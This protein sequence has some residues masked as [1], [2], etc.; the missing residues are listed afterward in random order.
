MH[1]VEG[2]FSGLCQGSVPM[3]VSKV[4]FQD[5]NSVRNYV[6]TVLFEAGQFLH[7]QGLAQAALDQKAFEQA[8]K[9]KSIYEDYR[10]TVIN[11]FNIIDNGDVGFFGSKQISLFNNLNLFSPAPPPPPK[12]SETE[13]ERKKRE[14]EAFWNK[15]IGTVVA[16]VAAVLAGFSYDDYSVQ[17]K[18]LS[19][20]TNISTNSKLLQD[21]IK[22][23]FQKLISKQLKIDRLRTAKATHNF[24]PVS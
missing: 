5:Q 20:T 8:R 12:D 24:L 1:I 6:Q 18:T 14:S 22:H 17:T 7:T 4:N 11:L 13:E 19:K 23:N 3:S 21:P 9:N 2:I 15:V 10:P 16:L